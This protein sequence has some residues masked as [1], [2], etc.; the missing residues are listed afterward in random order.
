MPEGIR[1]FTGNSNRILA[2]EIADFLNIPVGE[3]TISTFSDGESMVQINENVR[4]ADVFVIQSTC[5]P[6]NNNLM[7][8]LLMTPHD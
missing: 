6:V 3:A 1:L 8:L 5:M 4:G 7:E 2:G